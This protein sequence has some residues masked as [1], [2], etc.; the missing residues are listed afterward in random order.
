VLGGSG[1]LNLMVWDRASNVEYDN[2]GKLAG[3]TDEWGSSAIVQHIR[4][5]ENWEPPTPEQA[6]NDSVIITGTGTFGIGGPV[7]F[8]VDPIIP[9]HQKPFIPAM[10]AL[11]VDTNDNV[12]VF[13][14][15]V[16]LSMLII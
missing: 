7:Q 16:N 5:S 14:S 12:R 1:A 11:G 13:L 4:K 2:W 9:A 8:G 10:N 15:T 6:K 3:S